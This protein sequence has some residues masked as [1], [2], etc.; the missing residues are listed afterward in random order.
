M[1]QTWELCFFCP[2][3]TDNERVTHSYV[4]FLFLHFRCVHRHANIHIWVT[5]P[6]HSL[7]HVAKIS[8]L[9]SP[10]SLLLLCFTSFPAWDNCSIAVYTLCL[11]HKYPQYHPAHFPPYHKGIVFLV[12][13]MIIIYRIF[14]QLMLLRKKQVHNCFLQKTKVFSS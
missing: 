8:L 13:V 9:P 14:K 4:L 3:G 6:S 12:S 5:H 1:L 2:L 10:R 11:Y 7:T